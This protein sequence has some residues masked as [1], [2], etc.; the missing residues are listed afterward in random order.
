LNLDD[1]LEA[2]GGQYGDFAAQAKAS[3]LIKAAFAKCDNWTELDDIAR[4]ALETIAIKIS[5]LLTGNP[6]HY[7]SWHDIAG[8]AEL[9]ARRIGK[10]KEGCFIHEKNISNNE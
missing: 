1:T 5:R 6:E 3:Q 7:D 2:R 10:K 4:E 9:K 8:Y